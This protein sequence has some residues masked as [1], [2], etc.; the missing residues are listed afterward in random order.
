VRHVSLKSAIVIGALSIFWS[1]GAN[2]DGSIWKYT[3]TPCSGTF[4]SGLQ[5]LDDNP[6]GRAVAADGGY[7]YQLH[8]DGPI[9]KYTG[10][11]CSGTSCP[12]WQEFDDNPGQQRS[13]HPEV[14][15]TN[16]TTTAPSGC[17]HTHRAAERRVRAG[18]SSTT[19]QREKLLQH[20]QMICTNCTLTAPYG[21]THTHVQRTSCPGWQEPRRHPRANGHRRIRRQFVP[22]AQ[23]RLHLEVH[24]HTVQRNIVSWLAG[25][26]R[27]IPGQQIIPIRCN[28][29]PL[30]CRRF[31][32]ARHD[33]PLDTVRPLQYFED[34][35]LLQL[36]QITPAAAM[37]CCPGLS[38]SSCQPR[39]D[40]PA[41][42]CVCVLPDGAVVVQLVQIASGCGD[43]R[44]PGVVV[45]LLPART[46]RSA[47][48]CVCV[49]PYGAVSV[50]LVQS[51][52]YAAI[53]F[54]FGLSSSSC[55]PGHDVR[56]TV[57]M[58]TSRRS[59]RC[60]VWYRLPPMQR[61]LLPGVVVETSC[62][63]GHDVP[64]A[65][66]ARVL[67]DGAVTVQLVQ[68]TSIRCNSSS[69]WVVVELLPARTRCAACTVCRVLPDG[70]IGICA[71]RP[72]YRPV[73]R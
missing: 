49:H 59:R 13:L 5:Q 58:C 7:L 57:C 70:A 37:G 30:G 38:S 31:L 26:R 9:W 14:I 64:L 60:V 29:F 45:E 21:C 33:V 62:Q 24:I 34:A 19:T 11:P 46:R 6:K 72:E 65:R 36:V 67:P 73:R 3:G 22:T 15:C 66:R 52:A 39:H 51:F 47:A 4:V 8:S 12:G 56:C 27:Q 68:I 16:Y 63:P 18:R 55:Q 71:S 54:P 41:A 28:S 10:T 23:R 32:P 1:A 25:T 20:M 17:T 50:Q 61:S 40:V 42:R 43:G 48:R 2:A 53:A 35:S 69:F 44:C